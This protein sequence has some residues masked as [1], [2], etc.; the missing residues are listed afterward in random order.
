MSA[1]AFIEDNDDLVERCQGFDLH[2][3]LWQHRCH[4]LNLVGASG[5]DFSLWIKAL[6]DLV[7]DEDWNTAAELA[8]GLSNEC[9]K[10]GKT[11][12]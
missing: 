10:K 2:L 7:E 3:K 11:K 1:K 4:S 12:R 6:S 8:T 5:N 9:R